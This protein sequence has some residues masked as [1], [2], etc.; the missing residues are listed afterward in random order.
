MDS[1]RA[2]RR[3]LSAVS[4]FELVGWDVDPGRHHTPSTR[5]HT[6]R[7]PTSRSAS[8][9]RRT[10]GCWSDTLKG[11]VIAR[12]TRRARHS[13]PT[14]NSSP[15]AGSSSPPSGRGHPP[16]RPAGPPTA[17]R[18]SAQRRPARRKEGPRTADGPTSWNSTSVSSR[19]RQSRRL[20]DAPLRVRGRIIRMAVRTG[21]AL[22][23][24]AR[25][26]GGGVRRWQWCRGRPVGAAAR[27]RPCLARRVNRVSPKRRA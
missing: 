20:E 3:L 27:R 17:Y 11:I 1:D 12:T 7:L 19:R 18:D 8:G 22:F 9:P 13:T 23:R 26:A 4:G 16:A 15:A 25:R 21:G 24:L 6:E 2:G 5:Q 10:I 14:R